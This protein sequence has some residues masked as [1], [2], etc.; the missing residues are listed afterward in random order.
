MIPDVHQMVAI[1]EHRVSLSNHFSKIDDK[2][3]WLYEQ[4]IAVVDIIQ[5]NSNSFKVKTDIPN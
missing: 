4:T 1:D 5:V 2:M 3:V